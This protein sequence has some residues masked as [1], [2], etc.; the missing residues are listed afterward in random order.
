[1]GEKSIIEHNKEKLMDAAV[2]LSGGAIRGAFQVGVLKKISELVKAKLMKVKMI[3]GSSVGG[4][5]GSLYA[6]DGIR[7]LE[8][9]WTN[10]IHEQDDIFE[11]WNFGI[12]EGYFRGGAYSSNPLWELINTNIIDNIYFLM[13]T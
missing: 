12:P 1:M 4:L 13:K 3:T 6:Q 2:I 11:S 10:R 5:N 8:D 9:V 7:I